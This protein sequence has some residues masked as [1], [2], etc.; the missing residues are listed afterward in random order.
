MKN[1]DPERNPTMFEKFFAQI[2]GKY[3]A[4][5][6]DLKEGDEMDT[7]KKWYQ[8]KTMWSDL[9]TILVAAVG[10]ADVHFADGKI[11]TNPAYQVVLAALGAMGLDGRRNADANIR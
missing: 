5:K 3:V 7:T 2:A 6:L 4:K 10:F 8:S 1:N 11:A 9:T